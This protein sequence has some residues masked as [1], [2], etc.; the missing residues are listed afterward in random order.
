[1][2]S[3]HDPRPFV[4]KGSVQLPAATSDRSTA[5]NVSSY[6]RREGDFFECVTPTLEVSW[7]AKYASHAAHDGTLCIVWGSPRCGSP[8][9][10]AVAEP[11]T[12]RQILDRLGAS[13]H[14]GLADLRG[15]FGIFYAD[16]DGGQLI[17]AVDRFSI[18]TA[19]YSIQGDRIAFSDQAD[20]VP[21]QATRVTPQ[22]IYDYL[23]FHCIPAPATVF[24]GVGR[25]EYGSHVRLDQGRPKSDRH[26]NPRFEPGRASP[27]D[28]LSRQFR[29]LLRGVIAV[30]ANSG[31]KLGCFLSGGTDSST[32]AGMLGAVAGSGARTYSI[33]FDAAGYDEMEYARIAARHFGTDHHE[34]YLTADALLALIPRIAAFL[35]QPF[36]NSSLAPA[37]FCAQMAHA[38]GVTR[39]LAGDG[40]DELFGGNSRYSMQ[41]LLGAYGQI[42]VALREKLIEPALTKSALVGR[43]PVLKQAA[44]YVRHARN[45]MPDRMESF[46]LLSRI[47]ASRILDPGL[48]AAIDDAGPL[49]SQREVYARSSAAN[50]I[51]RIL[52]Y[53]WK[54][55]LADSD[56]PKVRSAIR[57][58]GMSV[59]YPL[60]ADEIVDFSMRLPANFKVR[61]YKLR[62]F[63][64]RA[65]SDF[66]PEAILRK[67]KHGFGLP[68]GPWAVQHAG[69]RNLAGDSL[70][71]L[72]ARAILRA[73]FRDELMGTLLP[74]HPGYYGELVW[75]LM[76]LEQWLSA[77]RGSAHDAAMA[78]GPRRRQVC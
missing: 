70:H 10:A 54:F 74:A 15:G 55:T 36:G 58:A 60:L 51:D 65:L 12:A 63:F 46:N 13:G 16:Q 30:E 23:Y 38:D 3:S 52:Q 24:E 37:Y 20:A 66:L 68:F 14:A 6:I 26:W 1:M 59:G 73:G 7:S 11:A 61:N 62:W 69:L 64:K 34:F 75:I 27:L 31:E 29:D 78:D 32:I 49:R 40:G 72:E 42:P 53:D 76:M 25:L 56:L 39:M 43:I 4:I 45:P 41:Q 50:G 48:L 9:S 19:C 35:D 67:K 57:L 71:A 2:I 47:G 5:G 8:H 17:I 21:V 44:G 77:H 22:S 28:A 18:E 33:G